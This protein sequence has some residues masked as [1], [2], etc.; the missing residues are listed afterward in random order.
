MAGPRGGG[1]KRREAVIDQPH[2]QPQRSRSTPREKREYVLAI[3]AERHDSADRRMRQAGDRDTRGMS[4]R[5]GAYAKLAGPRMSR[6]QNDYGQIPLSPSHMAVLEDVC[7]VAGGRGMCVGVRGLSRRLN[8]ER[9]EDLGGGSR[10]YSTSTSNSTSTITSTA[11][12]TGFGFLLFNRSVSYNPSRPPRRNRYI[13]KLQYSKAK[14]KIKKK[15]QLRL[16]SIHPSYLPLLMLHYYNHNYNYNYNADTKPA[17]GLDRRR[18]G[19]ASPSATV[20]NE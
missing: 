9:A 4:V 12:R 5:E 18:Q 19:W 7:S 15:V 14:H 10:L 1:T 6:A 8:R 3:R 16:L 11:D 2:A 13:G 17:A 20:K